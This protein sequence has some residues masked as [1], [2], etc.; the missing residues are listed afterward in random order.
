MVTLAGIAHDANRPLP[1]LALQANCS[2]DDLHRL[3]SVM[4]DPDTPLL[5]RF[6]IACGVQSR[7]KLD[8]LYAQLLEF[9]EYES[10]WRDFNERLRRLRLEE[11]RAKAREREREAQARER[12]LQAQ[13]AA[14]TEAM[15]RIQPTPRIAIEDAPGHNSKPDPLKAKTEAEF[16][17]A[18]RRYRVW[19]RNPS[20]RDMAQAC[21]WQVSHTTFRNM[22]KASTVPKRLD[23]VDAFVTALNGTPDDRRQWASAWRH[24]T[25]PAPQSTALSES[26]HTAGNEKPRLRLTGT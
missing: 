20:L 6:L 19:A 10:T 24:F 7:E 2:E 12:E 14:R 23:M 9:R 8:A 11:N 18:M 1:Q 15:R 25:V 5:P 21:G 17:D 26:E 3:I 16:V 22:L 13:M 4:G